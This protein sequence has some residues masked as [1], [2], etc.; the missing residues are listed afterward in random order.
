MSLLDL[1]FPPRCGGCGR[2]G[3][4]WCP[5]CADGLRP[6]S[7]G[8]LAGIPLVAA[9]RL[10][11]P[12]QRAIHAYKYRPRPQLASVLAQPLRRALIT[13]DVS[14]PAL[15]CVPLHP[16]RR[17]ERG[18]NQAER[19]AAELSRALGVPLLSGLTRVR[20]TPAQVGLSQAERRANLAGAFQWTATQPPPHGLGLVDDVCTTGATL[21]AAAEAVAE[22]GGSIGAFLVLAV[23][24][25]LPAGAVT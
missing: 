4:A 19:L 24:Q 8:T 10:E 9:G 5:S 11:G 25:T 6:A 2:Y 23:A 21:T 18:F 3:A 7:A 22:A 17:R 16:R 1:V 20:A 13:A 14:L 12:L 15:T